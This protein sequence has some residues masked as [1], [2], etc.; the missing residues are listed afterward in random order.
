M[1]MTEWKMVFKSVRICVS[2][3]RWGI[4]V[5][6]LAPVWFAD[7]IAWPYFVE[8]LTFGLC[9]KSSRVRQMTRAEEQGGL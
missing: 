4:A 7:R 1:R 8:W 6:V 2:L 9:N 5:Y 3:I